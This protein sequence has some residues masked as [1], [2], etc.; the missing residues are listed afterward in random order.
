MYSEILLVGAS[1]VYSK[2]DTALLVLLH[3]LLS[4]SKIA[5]AR[6]IRIIGA[7]AVVGEIQ[8]KIV[9]NSYVADRFQR[10]SLANSA[11]RETTS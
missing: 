8:V 11:R 9:L 5:A 2:F 7:C 6:L 4:L 3:T 10:E 1:L